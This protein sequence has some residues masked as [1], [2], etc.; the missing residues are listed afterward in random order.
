MRYY[1]AI[2]DEAGDIHFIDLAT[3]IEFELLHTYQGM[4]NSLEY[5][6][7]GRLIVAGQSNVVRVWERN[8]P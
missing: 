1:V 6:E 5:D 4:L 2:G 3:G 7:Q 8:Y